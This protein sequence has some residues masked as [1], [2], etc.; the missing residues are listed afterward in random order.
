MPG[1]KKRPQI[2]NYV[3]QSDTRKNIP[4]AEIEP[5]MGEDKRTAIRLEYER[6]S[7]NKDLDPQFVWRGKDEQDQSDLVVTAPPIFI[8]EK[9]HPRV[10]IEDLIRQ[11]DREMGIRSRATGFVRGLQRPEG[12]GPQERILRTRTELV[13][14]DDSGG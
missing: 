4:T 1:K 7:R 11:S 5:V 13:E 3:H 2:A 6:A 8:Q 14:Q 12:S 9:V 10:L